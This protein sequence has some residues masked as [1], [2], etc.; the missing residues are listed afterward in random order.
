MIA[1]FLAAQVLIA[2]VLMFASAGAAAQ[3]HDR[4]ILYTNEADI[5]QLQGGGALAVGDP[6]AVFLA[7]LN[8][9]PERVSVLPTENYYYVRFARNG[10]RYVGNIRLAAADRDKGKVHFSYGEEPTDW[11]NRPAARQATFGAGEGVSVEKVAALEYRV[12]AGARSVSFALND[13]SR[14]VPPQG[15]LMPDEIFLGPV[16]DEAGMRFFLVFNTRLKVFHF[17]LDETEAVA[18]EFLPGRASKTTVGKRTGFAFYLWGKRKILIGVS[19]RQ[20]RLN[21]WLDGPFDQ[22]PENFVDGDSLRDAI[23]AAEPGLRGKI[24]RLGNFADGS[25]RFL[26]HPY[27]LYREPADLSVFHRCMSSRAVRPAERPLCFVIS[28][29]EA[30]RR[31]PRPLALKRR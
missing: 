3:E 4:L 13:L 19:E 24:D 28:D 17:L 6:F 1:G 29:D 21:S 7:V 23:I 10:V 16:F 22:L 8:S 30:Q 14:V 27:M 12:T 18:D 20:S 25:T 26:V 2:F 9:L 31:S 11:N 15:V 5:A